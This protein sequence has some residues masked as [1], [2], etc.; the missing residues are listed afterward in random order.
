MKSN[1]D[2]CHLLV[3]TSNKVIIRIDNFDISNT[4]WEKLLG[5]KSDHKLTFDDHISQSCK[6]ACQKTH[7]LARVIPYMNIS[8]K[9]ILIN[10]VFESQ[11]SYCPVIW[12]CCS[13][14]NNW[15]INSLHERFLRIIYQDKQS[16]LNSC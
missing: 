6:S 16:S 5:V 1:S 9:R 12:M 8:K 13:C 10:A 7:A 15:K 4:K 11:F 3:S 14:I 2:N